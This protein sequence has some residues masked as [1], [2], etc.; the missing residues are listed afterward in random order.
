MTESR[1]AALFALRGGLFP[2]LDWAVRYF[3]ILRAL[4]RHAADT[5]PI[6]EIGSGSF[7]LAH[8]Y[9]GEIVGCDVNFPEVPERNM[10]PVRCSGTQLPFADSSFEAVVASDVLEHLPPD[11]R[12]QAVNEALRV[13]RK[14]A[15]FAFPCGK[16]AHALDEKFFDFHRKRNIPPPSWLEEHMRYPFPEQDLL[17]GV[18]EGW[19]VER[20]GN[21]HLRFHD[22]V[23]RREM[24]YSWCRVFRACLQFSPRLIEVG[25]RW[26]DRAP[27]YRMIIVVSRRTSQ[28]LEN[29]AWT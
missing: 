15:V 5:G 10:L 22:W 12:L 14:V 11:L 23:S 29:D 21:E 4:R 7:G 25:L 2:L 6:L 17:Q 3:P 1:A 18:G 26:A 28:G 16:D 13:T 24:S 9:R 27:F 19:K 20:F 8:F